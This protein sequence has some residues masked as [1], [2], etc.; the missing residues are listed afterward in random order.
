MFKPEDF[1]L[2]LEKELRLCTINTEIEE[3]KDID[4]LKSS[5]KEVTKQ[6]MQYQHL[7]TCVLQ[8]QLEQEIKNLLPDGK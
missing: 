2:P 7:L 8:K 5:L 3:C 4:V 6:L 1:H